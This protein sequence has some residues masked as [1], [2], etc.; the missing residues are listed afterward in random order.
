MLLIPQLSAR[1]LLT[2]VPPLFFNVWHSWLHT[3][4][5]HYPTGEYFSSVSLGVSFYFPVISFSSPYRDYSPTCLLNI[6]ASESSALESQSLWLLYKTIVLSILSTSFSWCICTI[7]F[8]LG[9][10]SFTCIY[11]MCSVDCSMV[12][13]DNLKWKV[14]FSF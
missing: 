7:L 2:S 3:I 13:T 6:Y 4:W 1:W 5:K 11:G 9:F 8:C 10:R 14:S 12:N